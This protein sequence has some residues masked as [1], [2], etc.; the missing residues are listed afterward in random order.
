[1]A[2]RQG[3]SFN[4]ILGRRKSPLASPS[5]EQQRARGNNLRGK[6]PNN[7]RFWAYFSRA[8][9]SDGTGV[10]LPLG[11]MFCVGGRPPSLP[12]FPL[13]HLSDHRGRDPLALQPHSSSTRRLNRAWSGAKRRGQAWLMQ[14]TANESTPL[15]LRSAS[16]CF[17]FAVL[18]LITAI[19]VSV[20]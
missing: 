6:I 3:G 2:S 10:L 7:K 12:F 17:Q 16:S 9:P 18:T 14:P 8:W 15:V 4:S 5:S 20:I 19:S 1:M 11:N 13:F